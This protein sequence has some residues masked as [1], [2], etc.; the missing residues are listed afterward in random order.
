MKKNPKTQTP[1]SQPPK[2]PKPKAPKPKAQGLVKFGL[3]VGPM[4]RLVL[5]GEGE[6]VDKG[7]TL[8][9]SMVNKEILE[10]VVEALERL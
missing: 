2:S 3:D 8:K 6:E 5:F 9:V 1:K 10:K 7:T 4:P